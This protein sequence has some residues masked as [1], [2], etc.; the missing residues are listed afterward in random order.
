MKK[1][2]VLPAGKPATENSSIGIDFLGARITRDE[3]G[4]AVVRSI[5]VHSPLHEGE[6]IH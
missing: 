3:D 4:T 6:R 2:G 1:S 5:Q